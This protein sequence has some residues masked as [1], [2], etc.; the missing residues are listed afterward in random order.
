M[1]VTQLTDFEQVVKMIKRPSGSCPRPGFDSLRLAAIQRKP[2][3]PPASIRRGFASPFLPSDF[4]LWTLDFGLSARCRPQP[5]GCPLPLRKKTCPFI[6]TL[7]LWLS[8]QWRAAWRVYPLEARAKEPQGRDDR[9]EKSA[10]EGAQTNHLAVTDFQAAENGL[11]PR[12]SCLC[13]L[14]GLPSTARI[15]LGSGSL[16]RPQV[17]L[18]VPDGRMPLPRFT[19]SRGGR[20]E[21]DNSSTEDR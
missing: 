20:S 4:R 16:A 2:H 7:V 19:A 11:P 14:T 13:G 21:P 1:W 15:R 6:Y 12:P 9:G 10:G 3:F 18:W 5:P 8:L 17:W